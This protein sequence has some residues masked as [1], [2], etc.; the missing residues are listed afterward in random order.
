ME[1]SKEIVGIREA[2]RYYDT[3]GEGQIPTHKLGDVMRNLG[4]NLRRQDLQEL[5]EVVDVDGKWVV[6]TP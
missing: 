2:F 1:F 3:K 6:R 4:Q 5:L